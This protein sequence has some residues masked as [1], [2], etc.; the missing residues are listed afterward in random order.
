MTIQRY[1]HIR[2]YLF[3]IPILFLFSGCD[4][5]DEIFGGDE[6]VDIEAQQGY[7]NEI[8]D[9]QDDAGDILED[10]FS[11]GLD[12]TSVKDSVANYFKKNN[13]VE[14]VW[15]NSRGVAVEYKS[16]FQGGIFLS[17]FKKTNL[18]KIIFTQEQ[19][20]KIDKPV[21]PLINPTTTIF[22]EP[23]YQE[24]K[25]FADN[26]IVTSNI[27]F[28]KIHIEDFNAVFDNNAKL[29]V[30]KNL[31]QY[32]LIH[33]AGHGWA[34][35][36]EPDEVGFRDIFYLTGEEVTK[37]DIIKNKYTIAE[38]KKILISSIYSYNIDDNTIYNQKRIWISPKYISDNNKFKVDSTVVYG[39]FCYSNLGNWSKELVN[40]AGAEVYIGYDSWVDATP[41]QEWIREFYHDLC[42]TSYTDPFVVEQWYN[43]L[44]LAPPLNAHINIDDKG[45]RVEISFNGNKDFSFWKDAPSELLNG[46]IEFY[47]DEAVFKRT[48]D[49]SPFTGTL[50]E[51][52]HLNGAN[53][54]FSN[55]V[56]NGNYWYQS[57]GRTFSGNIK[58]TFIDNPESINIHLDNTMSYVS[59]LFG[60]VEFKYTVDYAG[61]P[62]EGIDP[63]SGYFVYSETGPS[64][65]KIV[66]EWK[67]NNDQFKK[68]LKSYSCGAGAYIRVEVDKRE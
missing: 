30:L 58:I 14:N 56:F 63:N 28:R 9:I 6:E 54:S 39:G 26:N 11:S 66:V 51:T 5:I 27:E 25:K 40:I 23:A 43:G 29:S 1:S 16:G 3:I 33:L 21:I 17:P 4:I 42:D 12:T 45:H 10:L 59:A 49:S 57:L 34:W 35:P 38:L 48:I 13:S 44:V 20:L 55:N 22:I 24:F 37:E 64:V 18:S 8:I 47:L 61:L 36:V 7:I 52:L 50:G 32:G 31:S 46:K 41:D 65:N 53:G 2:K 62:I 67:E 19:K 15:I 68:E 60:D